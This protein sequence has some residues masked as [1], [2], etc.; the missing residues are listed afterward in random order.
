MCAGCDAQSV[1]SID[2]C[3]R[4]VAL[5]S[6]RGHGRVATDQARREVSGHG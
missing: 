4:D 6:H 2:T 5:G 3:R 1:A